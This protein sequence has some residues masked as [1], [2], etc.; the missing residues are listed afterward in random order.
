MQSPMIYN[1]ANAPAT[2]ILRRFATT[3]TET[4]EWDP[5]KDEVVEVTVGSRTVREIRPQAA[6]TDAA[7]DRHQTPGGRW[8]TIGGERR[9]WRDVKRIWAPTPRYNTA[10]RWL[11]SRA[12][13]DKATP[14]A[15]PVAGVAIDNQTLEAE[16]RRLVA[17]FVPFSPNDMARKK[18]QEARR[19]RAARV[20]PYDRKRLREEMDE[21]TEACNPFNPVNVAARDAA[22]AELSASMAT[23]QEYTDNGIK[24]EQIAPERDL[25]AVSPPSR[26]EAKLTDTGEDSMAPE[27][28]E[29]VRGRA[30]NPSREPGSDSTAISSTPAGRGYPV[31]HSCED[32]SCG[33]CSPASYGRGDP[34]SEDL[35]AAF[36]KRFPRLETTNSVPAVE[37]VDTEQL[38]AEM[39]QNDWLSFVPFAEVF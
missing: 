25:H 18:A 5:S 28:A 36:L 23:S 10:P 32:V 1:N 37:R 8:G 17:S 11:S 26:I 4:I 33:V 12:F 24:E 6:E 31:Q 3:A 39:E 38:K 2:T 16:W 20:V 19:A 15:M 22:E 9:M 27:W 14:G 30:S 29:S 7:H 13:S 35:S 21:R 34:K